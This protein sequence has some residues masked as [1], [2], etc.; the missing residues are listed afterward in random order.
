MRSKLPVVKTAQH[1]ELLWTL[2]RAC[3]SLIRRTS[4]A[5]HVTSIVSIYNSVFVLVLLVDIFLLNLTINQW[6]WQIMN[7]DLLCGADNLPILVWTWIFIKIL[8][9]N[10]RVVVKI[11]LLY[12]GSFW[13]IE[14]IKHCMFAIIYQL[15]WFPFL[16]LGLLILSSDKIWHML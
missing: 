5:V 6:F 10:L 13:H 11:L 2:M 9:C 15:V 8:H 12:E 16:N 14:Q 3:P 7:V 1:V 4:L